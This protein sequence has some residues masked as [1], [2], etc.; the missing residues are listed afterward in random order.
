M[1][2]EW[3]PV[4][5]IKKGKS[6]SDHNKKPD[7]KQQE[8]EQEQEQEGHTKPMVNPP[9]DLDNI[10]TGSIFIKNLNFS[11]SEESLKAH[12][13]RLGIQANTIRAISIPKKKKG[14][15]ILSMGFG[16]VEFVSTNYV[17]EA[18]KRLNG[19]FLDNHA[20]E[21]KPSDKK[22]GN[23]DLVSSSKQ[24]LSM[25][26][27]PS[28]KLSNKLLVRNIAFQANQ[29]EL[30]ILFATFGQ[31][32]KIRMPKKPGG[33]HRGFAF[34]DFSTHQ[35]AV[36]AMTALAS[37]HLYGRH[38][39]I[40]WAKEDDDNLE[41]LRKRANGDIKAINSFK[42]TNNKDAFEGGAEEDNIEEGDL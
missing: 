21:V 15:L 24:K 29:K 18:L 42:K 12:L 35:E 26:S 30:H 22:L 38:L 1:Y 16:F 3:A 33:S 17:I 11:T 32:K 5:V 25:Q 10:E 14:E 27:D 37:T 8:Q 23:I 19:S 7:I 13:A 40:E 34:I 9:E 4:N 31:L 6:P 39:V 2:L 41:V 28:N 36:N 20:L